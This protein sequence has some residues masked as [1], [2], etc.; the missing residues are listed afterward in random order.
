MNEIWAQSRGVAGVIVSAHSRG[1]QINLA[2]ELLLVDEVDVFF[3][4]DFYGQTY[5]QVAMMQ[6]EEVFEIMI[7]LWEHREERSK[8]FLTLKM[9][10][11]G[12]AA[13]SSLLSKYSDW[14]FFLERETEAMCEDLHSYDKTPFHYDRERQ[15]I[16]YQ[17][18]DGYDYHVVYRYRTAFAYL[19]VASKGGLKKESETLKSVLQL[20]ISCGQFSYANF[21]KPTILGV[22]GTV[23][24]LGKNEW[25]IMSNFGIT[26]YSSMPSVYG[27]SNFKYGNPGLTV[28]D[29]DDH[30]RDIVAQA[31]SLV[32][33][34]IG[35]AVIVFF[36]DSAH[37]QAFKNSPYFK[38]MVLKHVLDETLDDKEKEYVIKKAATPRQITLATASFGRGTDFYCNDG[39]LE[40]AGG[41]E[42][43]LAFVPQDKSEEIQ[44]QGR[45]A[46][47]GKK[48]TCTW[49]VHEDEVTSLDINVA[50]FRVRSD[51]LEQLKIVDS[52]RDLKREAIFS[53]I[54]D[55]L[56]VADEKDKLTRAYFKSLLE[57][58]AKKALP[59]FEA[60]YTHITPKGKM[61]GACR[62][63]C[64]SDATGSM[65]GIWAAT[66][67]QI[68]KMLQ[69]VAEFAGDGSLELQWIA[70][71]DYSDPQLIEKSPWC[72]G[73]EAGVLQSFVA[74]ISCGGGGDAEE[75]VERAL[76]EARRE[77]AIKPL[78][79]VILIG[80]APPHFELKGQ[81][82][83][84]HAHVLETDYKAE[85][86]EL[87]KLNVPVFSF[88][89]GRHEK[90]LKTF[91]DISKPAGFTTEGTAEYLTDP[92]QLINVVCVKALEAIGGSEL[93][94]EYTKKYM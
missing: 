60:L 93:V 65:G 5:N 27:K 76:L 83:T 94:A 90:T 74:G 34:K 26:R 68:V 38:K 42:V 88:V 12:C 89:V 40:E 55:D 85:A 39:R 20:R 1:Q 29:R 13:Y 7:F 59:A 82:L 43:V 46:R 73:T 71:R 69:R 63:V 92:G 6:S 3:G 80:D 58:S 70:Y 35:R 56:K 33:P 4:R 32:D 86:K 91:E 72:K 18:M 22:S 48:G 37:L 53:K 19:D 31:N 15:K 10:K 62:M 14:K 54:W 47:Q 24:S 77:H 23:G 52:A 79:R 16:G 51:L 50:S 41:V 2:Q 45:T 87:A 84:H 49:I 11:E 67:E 36:R 25:N 17:V 28:S 57:G 30:F 66:Q 64:L 8:P 44:I 78:S 81:R 9:L 75:A 21:G 61:L